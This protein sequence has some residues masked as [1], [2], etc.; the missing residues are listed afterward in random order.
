[1]LSQSACVLSLGI[2]QPACPWWHFVHL[3][4]LGA[5]DKAVLLWKA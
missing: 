2:M 3:A 5:R 4:S 1:M